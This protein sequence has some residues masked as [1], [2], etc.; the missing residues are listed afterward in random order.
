MSSN[1]LNSPN[2]V[3]SGYILDS[4]HW[5]TKL[6]LTAIRK[7]TAVLCSSHWKKRHIRFWWKQKQNT[8]TNSSFP[9]DLL[10]ICM[11]AFAQDSD[12]YTKEKPVQP[13]Q[14]LMQGLVTLSGTSFPPLP[15]SSRRK[16]TG[17]FSPVSAI[18]LESI[19]VY[20]QI[21]SSWW[22]VIISISFA[23]QDNF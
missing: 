12:T 14:S 16:D 4:Y 6:W 18:W 8:C 10:C 23:I 11:F 19:A 3:S 21:I 20:N 1:S 7:V 22:M 17:T 9:E 15:S 2:V 5:A 13:L